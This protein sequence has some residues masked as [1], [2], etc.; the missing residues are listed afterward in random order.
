MSTLDPAMVHPVPG[1]V[2]DGV[3]VIL[4]EIGA[5]MAY[6]IVHDFDLD[7]FTGLP[8]DGP[9]EDRVEAQRAAERLMEAL[10]CVSD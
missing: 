10:S 7:I 6:Y 8:G 9:Y 2:M 5:S 1:S 3:R 4:R